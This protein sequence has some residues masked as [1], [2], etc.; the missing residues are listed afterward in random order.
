M[1]A[2]A[3]SCFMYAVCSIG[4][5][6][7]GQEPVPWALLAN[8]SAV[9]AVLCTVWMFMRWGRE[10]RIDRAEER[11]LLLGAM[12]GMSTTFAEKVEQS[13]KVVE[14]SNVRSENALASLATELRQHR[15]ANGGKPS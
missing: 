1:I 3:V 10:E 11:K 15:V 4:S 14:A 8:G 13:H 9:L 6:V 12:H 7:Q 5:V 2:V